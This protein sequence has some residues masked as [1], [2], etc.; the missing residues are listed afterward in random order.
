MAPTKRAAQ[1]KLVKMILLRSKRL[2]DCSLPDV[3]AGRVFVRRVHWVAKP[4]STSLPRVSIFRSVLLAT[5][6]VL[7]LAVHR[8]YDPLNSGSLR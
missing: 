4:S 6:T 2:E 7:G 3:P 1:T 5:V 8:L